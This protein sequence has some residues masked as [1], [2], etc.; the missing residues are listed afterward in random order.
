MRAMAY[1]RYGGP[2]VLAPTDLPCPAA[3]AGGVVIRVAAAVVA[4]G[5][6]RLVRA[7]PWAVRLY[8]G[9]WRIRRPVLGHGMSGT[10]VEVGAGS[11]RWRVGQEVYGESLAGGG[12]AQFAAVPEELLIEKPDSASHAEAACTPVA[13]FTALQGLRDHGRLRAGGRVLVV[14]ASGGVGSTAVPL[15]KLLGAHVTAVASKRQEDFVRDL[16]ADEFI[17]YSDP[18]PARGDFTRVGERWDVILDLVG[19]RSISGC[20]RALAEG[21]RYVAVSG[22]LRRTAWLSL[23]GGSGMTGMI[24][25][26]NAADL[27]WLNE[28]LASREL[29][30]RIDR[31]YPLEELPE[32]MRRLG[33]GSIRGKLALEL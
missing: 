7:D 30:P 20:K 18:D 10:V 28:R 1:S 15:A 22:A 5:D 11:A 4:S 3:A 23:F 19:D 17:D 25:K 12:F 13:G 9:L 26:P 29:T 16:G 2:E 6:W 21:G 24:A 27:Q 33:A 8:Q 14:G 31:S 32:A